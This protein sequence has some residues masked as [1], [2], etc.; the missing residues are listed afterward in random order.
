MLVF[1]MQYLETLEVIYKAI[2]VHK[3][4]MLIQY[5]LSPERVCGRGYAH[6]RERNSA[7]TV[8]DFVGETYYFDFA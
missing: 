6:A 5:E 2:W 3:C 8:C 7:G 4:W 1:Q